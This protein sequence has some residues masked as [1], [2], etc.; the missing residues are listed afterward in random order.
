[1]LLFAG[2]CVRGLIHFPSPAPP[3]ANDNPDS[4]DEDIKF[5][6][7]VLFDA[8]LDDNDAVWVDKTLRK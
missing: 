7:D 8:K 6:E 3:K 1:V 5:E 4:D 2:T